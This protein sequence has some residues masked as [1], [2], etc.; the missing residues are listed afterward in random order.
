MPPSQRTKLLLLNTMIAAK[1][2][3]F[4]DGHLDM[5]MDEDDEDELAS[6]KEIRRK[7][8][9][10]RHYA[11]RV[12]PSMEDATFKKHFRLSRGTF[13]ALLI[14]LKPILGKGRYTCIV[15]CNKGCAFM[16]TLHN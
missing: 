3:L 12:V 5:L 4:S 1:N 8:P 16:M 6:V 13:E 11:E 7:I 10:A 15:T 2:I 9:K 14:K